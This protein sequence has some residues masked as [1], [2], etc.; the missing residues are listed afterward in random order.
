MIDEKAASRCLGFLRLARQAVD[1]AELLFIQATQAEHSLYPL[2]KISGHI[3]LA[4]TNLVR[5]AEQIDGIRVRLL[6]EVKDAAP[7]NGPAA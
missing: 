7:T 6:A 1:D 2:L 4:A 3:A 5:A